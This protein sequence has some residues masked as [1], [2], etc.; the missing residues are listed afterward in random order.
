MVSEEHITAFGWATPQ[1]LDEMMSLSLRINDFLSG[2]FLGI[3]MRLMDLKLEFGRLW[4]DDQVRI[5]LADEICPDSC[6]L[7]DIRTNQRLDH[8]RVRTATSASSPT[9]TRRW[10]AVSAS[11]RRAAPPT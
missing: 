9:P 8:E 7:W 1:D 10:P 3:G 2:L 4:E 5:V 11:C 6:R